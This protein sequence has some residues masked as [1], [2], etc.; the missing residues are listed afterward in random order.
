MSLQEH[1]AY[2]EGFFDALDG[3]P[4]F[5]DASREYAAGWRAYY[6]VRDLLDNPNFTDRPTDLAKLPASPLW[7]SPAVH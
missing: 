1:P 3:E 2:H 7:P 6:S 4:L 5:D